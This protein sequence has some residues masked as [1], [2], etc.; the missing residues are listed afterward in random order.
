ME[1]KK[2]EIHQTG[3]RFTMELVDGD[4]RSVLFSD[5]DGALVG[6]QWWLNPALLNLPEELRNRGCSD[7]QIRQALESLSSGK[8]THFTLTLSR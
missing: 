2:I 1:Q 6:H 5:K 3:G 7:A 4:R 8:D